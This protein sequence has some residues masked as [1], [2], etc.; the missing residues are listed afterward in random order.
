[1]RYCFTRGVARVEIAIGVLII[2]AGAVLGIVAFYLLP[3]YYPAVWSHPSLPA[4]RHEP[5]ARALAAVLLFGGGVL[6]GTAFIVLGQLILVF[7][8]I[9]ARLE[10]I[11]RRLRNRDTS[12]AR[13]S[14]LT[15][16]LRPR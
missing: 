6:I 9:R 14:P 5:V 10:R 1:M 16:R 4:E 15:E 8:D 3:Q 13:E 11:D 7:L 2:V 12:T